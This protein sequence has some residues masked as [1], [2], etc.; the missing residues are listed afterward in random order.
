MKILKNYEVKLLE[1]DGLI[2]VVSSEDYNTA[3]RYNLYFKEAKIKRIK[4]LKYVYHQTKKENI[5]DILSNGL[6][7][8]DSRNWDNEDKS[9]KY[10]PSIFAINTEI[11]LSPFYKEGDYITVKI[12]TTKIKN[13][14]WKDLNIPNGKFIMTFEPMPPSAISNI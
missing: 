6:I 12:D 14:W 10:P 1:K 13:K 7:P 8:F 5:D 11:L 9:L 4:P 3:I 2:L